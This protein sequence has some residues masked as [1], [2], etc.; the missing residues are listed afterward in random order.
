MARLIMRRGGSP[1]RDGPQ[2]V[3]QAFFARVGAFVVRFRYPV[4]AAWV[5]MAVA[6][7]IGLPSLAARHARPRIQAPR[8]PIGRHLGVS[9][10]L[11]RPSSHSPIRQPRWAHRPVRRRPESRRS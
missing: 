1:D 11:Q 2:D 4:V 5:L 9:R 7:T 8:D 10:P 3:I 6:A